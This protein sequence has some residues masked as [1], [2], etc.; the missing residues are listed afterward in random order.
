MELSEMM[1]KNRLAMLPFSFFIILG[2]VLGAAGVLLEMF[3]Y[4][5]IYFF[6][7]VAVSY[8]LGKYSLIKYY[9]SSDER[10]F[11]PFL[12]IFFIL[13]S[14]LHLITI[15]ALFAG[16]RIGCACICGC[17]PPPPPYKVAITSFY[18]MLFSFPSFLIAGSYPLILFSQIGLKN[19]AKRTLKLIFVVYLVLILIFV[20]VSFEN[21]SMELQEYHSQSN[22]I[23]FYHATDGPPQYVKFVAYPMCIYNDHLTIS[24]NMEAVI[25]F[26]HYDNSTGQWFKTTY[27]MQEAYTNW[28]AGNASGI[29]YV[30]ADHDLR[31]SKGDYILVPGHE[32]NSADNYYLYMSGDYLTS[33]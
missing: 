4:P 2:V 7:F 6:F 3:L 27:T 22:K 10:V 8:I 24:E 28:Q 16:P 15:Q 23:M 26:S 30:D 31:I 21:A 11:R 18:V 12:L 14:V 13:L 19:L 5:I 25:H 20:S 17:G 29:Q 32:I 1:K 33:G 9:K